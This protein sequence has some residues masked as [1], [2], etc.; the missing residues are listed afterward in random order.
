[1]PIFPSESPEQKP[2]RGG[3]YKS[4]HQ[5]SNPDMLILRYKQ[6]E[7]G[8]TPD[9]AR[10]TKYEGYLPETLTDQEREGFN[11]SRFYL[12]KALHTIN[13]VL[14]PD[15]YYSSNKELVVEKKLGTPYD[16]ERIPHKEMNEISSELTKAGLRMSVIDISGSGNFIRTP[17]GFSYIDTVVNT[18]Y[19]LLLRIIRTEN[20]APIIQGLSDSEYQEFLVHLLVCY[21]DPGS[22]S[23]SEFSVAVDTVINQCDQPDRLHALLNRYAHHM[24]VFQELSESDVEDALIKFIEADRNRF[25]RFSDRHVHFHSLKK[26][27]FRLF[28]R[29]RPRLLLQLLDRHK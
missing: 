14:F 11:R 4:V 1:M 9:P 3:S 8:M 12:R 13:P 25:F 22:R 29:K 17:E 19:F 21:Y 27:L 7:P 2:L 20:L 23:A 28:L 24:S 10:E 18:H 5:H 6:K 26:D 15:C 16:W